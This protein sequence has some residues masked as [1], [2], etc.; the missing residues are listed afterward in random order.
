MEEKV[1]SDYQLVVGLEVHVQLATKS[2]LFSSDST[3]YGQ[4]A[5]TNVSVI[6]LA[7][8]GTMPRLNKKAVEYAIRMG[9]AC[10]SEIS[11][12]CIFDRKNYFYPDLPKGFQTTQDQTPICI[13]GEIAV[14]L[15]DQSEVSI[16]LNRIHLEEDAGKSIH[17]EQS[18]DSLIDLNRAGVPLIELVTEPVI[19]T[20]EEAMVLLAEIRRMVRYLEICDGNMEQGSLRCDANISVKKYEETQLGKKVEVKNMNSIRNVGRAIEFE[21]KR[22]I[23][24]IEQGKEV[25]SETRLFDAN[26]GTTASMRA[27]EELNDYRYFPEPD[28]SPFEVSE[29]WLN[30]IRNEMPDTPRQFRNKF[31]TEYSLSYYDAAVLT[32]DLEI[33]KFFN[34]TCQKTTHYKR[35]ANWVMGSIKSTLNE[36]PADLIRMPLSSD[37]LADLVDLIEDGT[38]NSSIARNNVYPALIHQTK[39]VKE[40]LNDLEIELSTEDDFSDVILQVLD[41]FPDKVKAYQNGKKNL[42]GMFMG[43]VMRRTKGTADPKKMNDLLI[44]AL[45]K[46]N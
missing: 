33:A 5:N 28:L 35:V 19:S 20:A 40:V 10:N 44:D 24:L 7:H 8:P 30:E 37:Q 45:Q 46:K 17:D 12:Y 34:E 31:Q 29:Q 2:K 1:N 3:A 42:L 11:R 27:K 23:L 22:Q 16:K 25:I 39:S 43:E 4:P 26:K 36:Q 41:A 18:N 21:M 15:K 14:Q 9:L 32:D 13:G 38:L 6:T